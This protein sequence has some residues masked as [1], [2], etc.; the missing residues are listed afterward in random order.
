MKDINLPLMSVCIPTYNRAERLQV[1]IHSALNSSYS[2]LEIIVSDNGSTD[3]TEE[4]CRR[5]SAAN[6]KVRY[7]RHDQNLGA[8]KNFEFARAQSVGTY[9]MWLG[10]DDSLTENYVSQCIKRLESDQD[11][12]LVSGNAAYHKQDGIITHQGLLHDL[13]SDNSL[14]R[15]FKYLFLVGDNA[16]FYGVYRAEKI[17][18]CWIPDCFAGDWVWI[19][20]VLLR[21]KAMMM[22]E[23]LIKREYGSNTAISH[24]NIVKALGLP[25]WQAKFPLLATAINAGNFL[26]FDCRRNMLMSRF[27]CY[28][29]YSLVFLATGLK[30][31]IS[32][33]RLW[34]PKIPFAKK[35][36]YKLNK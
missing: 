31:F 10:D 3:Q 28:S 17:A 9:F 7:F 27:F 6:G 11:L 26:T 21:G 22:P 32:F 19:A 14:C 29:I 23:V 4:L 34:V 1:A 15:V 33:L 35:I 25:K 20:Q 36:Y 12:V 2:N 30:A 5:I 24:A 16:I 18:K 8:T 13:G